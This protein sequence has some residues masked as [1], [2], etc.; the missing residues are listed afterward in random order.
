[1]TTKIS[2][3][4]KIV[5]MKK[6]NLFMLVLLCAT[7]IMAQSRKELKEANISNQTEWKYDYSSGKEVKYKVAE[8][9]Y[10]ANG[11]VLL[12]KTYNEKG[13]LETY[14]EHEYDSNGNQIVEITYDTKGKVLKREEFKYEGKLKVEKKT[15]T[16]DGKLKSKKIYE[17]KTF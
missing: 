3:F 17:Y 10:D 2:C 15:F 11:N 4:I 1:M 8:Y 14:F 13:T 9:Q 7:T 12:E 16:P 6:L 5:F